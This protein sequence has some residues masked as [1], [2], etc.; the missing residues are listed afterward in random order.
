MKQL[1]HMTFHNGKF[2]MTEQAAGHSISVLHLTSYL[3]IAGDIITR[4][5]SVIYLTALFGKIDSPHFRLD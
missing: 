5:T 4:K 3:N 1:Q 2:L